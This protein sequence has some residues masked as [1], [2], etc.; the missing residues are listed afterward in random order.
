MTP[1]RLAT[2][3]KSY[4][5]SLQ[6][7][8]GTPERFPADQRLGLATWAKFHRH[9]LWLATEIP[10]LVQQGRLEKSFRWLGF[11]QGALW[12]RGMITIEDLK[13]H[14]RSP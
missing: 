2:I 6:K 9:L 10:S 12:A 3:A 4:A 5:E 11:I 8:A 7:R 13:N 1:E 14:N